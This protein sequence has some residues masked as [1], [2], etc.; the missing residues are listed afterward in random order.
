VRSYG[1][2]IA[3]AL[4][5]VCL[6]G[7][8]RTAADFHHFAA[9]MAA[10]CQAVACVGARLS[11]PRPIRIDRNPDNYT[12][13]VATNTTRSRLQCL[14]ISLHSSDNSERRSM[15]SRTLPCRNCFCTSNEW[16]RNSAVHPQRWHARCLGGHTALFADLAGQER[17]L[18]TQPW[19]ISPQSVVSSLARVER[20]VRRCAPH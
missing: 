14:R 5:A 17:M 6:P 12:L 3:S 11:R 4:P 13:P 7:P 16:N 2:R 9:A 19:E 15:E 20:Q 10:V 1:S 18:I 8:A